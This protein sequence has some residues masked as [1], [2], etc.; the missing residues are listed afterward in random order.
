VTENPHLTPQ[1][2]GIGGLV[3][4][5]VTG[6]FPRA[7]MGR[8]DIFLLKTGPSRPE[9]TKQAEIRLASLLKILRI[10]GAGRPKHRAGPGKGEERLHFR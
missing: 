2:P 6:S 8:V 10:A 3:S 7:M 4:Q 5:L 9:S 1:C